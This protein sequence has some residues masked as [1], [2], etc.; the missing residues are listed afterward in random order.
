LIAKKF[1]KATVDRKS[2]QKLLHHLALKAILIFQ[3]IFPSQN[4]LLPN[5]PQISLS[6]N[7]AMV[8]VRD[9]ARVPRDMKKMKW[10]MDQ[11]GEKVK[12]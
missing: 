3:D 10:Q 11:I 2:R 8:F 9:D 12:F 4:K 1:S 6:T 7:F 5:S